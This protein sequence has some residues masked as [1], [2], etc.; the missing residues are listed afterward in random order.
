MGRGGAASLV[1]C[2]GGEGAGRGRLRGRGAGVAA[3]GAQLVQ[4]PQ[5]LLLVH[6]LERQRRLWLLRRAACRAL[7][8][9]AQGCNDERQEQSARFELD[10]VR[11]VQRAVDRLEFGG[12]CEQLARSRRLGVR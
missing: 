9:S 1:A 4:H 6:L 7:C 8:G 12:R 11:V 5:V 10:V 3:R 2:Q